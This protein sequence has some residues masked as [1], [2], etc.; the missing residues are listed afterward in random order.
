MWPRRALTRPIFLPLGSPASGIEPWLPAGTAEAAGVAG[1]PQPH[2][3]LAVH[4]ERELVLG[5]DPPARGALGPD[6][7]DDVFDVLADRDLLVGPG[8][9]GHL[10]H[11]G[12]D[13]VPW[14]V[15][16]DLDPALLK[17]LER[18]EVSGL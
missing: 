2:L 18:A 17:V 3:D 11:V 13:V 10:E 7:L 15:L 5:R 1:L 16:D 4:H 14:I 6:R 8:L 12:K 9:R